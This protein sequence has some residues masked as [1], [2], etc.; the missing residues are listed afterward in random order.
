[1]TIAKTLGEIVRIAP[2]YRAS[3]SALHCLRNLARDVDFDAIRELARTLGAQLAYETQIQEYESPQTFEEFITSENIPGLL[4]VYAAGFCPRCLV[5]DHRARVQLQEADIGFHQFAVFQ[6]LLRRRSP[7]ENEALR[8]YVLAVHMRFVEDSAPAS[9]VSSC[10]RIMED[11]QVTEGRNASSDLRFGRGLLLEMGIDSFIGVVSHELGHNIR[12]DRRNQADLPTN[13]E[14]LAEIVRLLPKLKKSATILLGEPVTDEDSRKI[15]TKRGL[16]ILYTIHRL[17]ESY[18]NHISLSNRGGPLELHNATSFLYLILCALGIQPASAAIAYSPRGLVHLGFLVAT[19][20]Y[21]EFGLREVMQFDTALLD[22]V[23][24]DSILWLDEL[25]KAS[26]VGQK[27]EDLLCLLSQEYARPLFFGWETDFAI[28]AINACSAI[29]SGVESSGMTHDDLNTL[30]FPAVCCGDAPL[31]EAL[32][33]AG[34]SPDPTTEIDDPYIIRSGFSLIVSEVNGIRSYFGPTASGI[35]ATME[36]L[37]RAGFD[38]NSA[39]NG[40]GDTLLVDAAK[41]SAE[42]VR[43]LLTQGADVDGA[44]KRGETAL[45]T[46]ASVRNMDIVRELIDAGADVN[47]PAYNGYSPLLV[48]LQEGADD[49][50]E[51][52][53]ESGADATTESNTWESALMFAT[54]STMTNLLCEAGANVNAASLYGETALMRAANWGGSSV[55]KTLL[56]AGADVAAVTDL[57]ETALHYAMQNPHRRSRLEVVGY[58]IGAGA[59]VDA[60]TDD[61]ITPLILAVENYIG[62]LYGAMDSWTPY[63]LYDSVDDRLETV[64]RAYC[65]NMEQQRIALHPPGEESRM[66][67][68]ESSHGYI[69]ARLLLNQRREGQA[70]FGQLAGDELGEMILFNEDLPQLYAEWRDSGL[71]LLASRLVFEKAIIRLLLDA[72]AD[73]ATGSLEGRSPLS[74]VGELEPEDDVRVLIH[75]ARSLGLG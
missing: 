58:L 50:A 42:T 65:D 72:G 70:S 36:A 67:R 53:I 62:T 32:L 14:H 48:A 24:G 38:V 18:F 17:D 26:R 27:E 43:F 51:L 66:S 45:Y 55:V 19:D 16:R 46:A 57:G 56:D 13:L 37:L 75:G 40:D 34:A 29:R 22:R 25:T 64:F 11:C 35:F 28:D 30:L 59:E 3:V 73:V 74:L 63:S 44:N 60:E 15:T 47:K 41:R 49:V 4:R 39:I 69:R 71:D 1:M 54:S 9:F 12:H 21:D 68:M 6:S 5:L 20:K 23:D 33:A 31:V 10:N 7:I 8:A 52:L 61:G 2:T